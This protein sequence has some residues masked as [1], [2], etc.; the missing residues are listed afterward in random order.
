MT[1]SD[2]S[3]RAA[4]EDLPLLS[5]TP[6]SWGELAADNLAVFLSDHAVCEQQA[7]LFALNLVARYPEDEELVES[8]CA[9]AAEEVVHLRRVANLLHR[10]GLS[11]GRRRSNPY[12]QGLRARVRTEREPQLKVDR[13]LVGALIEARSCERFTRLLEVIAGRDPEVERLL[14]DL[15]PAEK[16]HWKM[17]HD[18]ASREVE[19]AWFDAHWREW[20]E[21]E[22][23]LISARGTSPTVHG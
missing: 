3:R 21:A 20:L 18:L 9:L 1:P 16:R 13:L 7:A 23:E 17:F 8:M 4:T 10:R 12:V 6:R 15:G 2:A 19:A 11:V 22:H 5:L 14:A